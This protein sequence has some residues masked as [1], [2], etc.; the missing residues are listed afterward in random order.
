MKP[1][2]FFLCCCHQETVEFFRLLALC[3]TVMV[4]DKTPSESIENIDGIDETGELA[5]NV[6]L[7]CI[8]LGDV[9]FHLLFPRNPL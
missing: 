8:V 3:H 4:E 7:R 2:I 9:P 1:Y 5:C 6:F